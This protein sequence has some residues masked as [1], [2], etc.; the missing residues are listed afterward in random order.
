[1]EISLDAEKTYSERLMDF[2]IG[3]DYERI[4]PATVEAAKLHMLDAIGVA[5]VSSRSD[6]AETVT[7]TANRLGGHADCSVFGREER[8][9]A[10]SAAFV[11]ASMVHTPDYD[12]THGGSVIH[13]SSVVVPVAVAIAEERGIPGK[14]FL[15]AL[16]AGYEI[17]LRIGLCA[18]GKFHRNGFHPT[19]ACG[20][21]GSTAVAARLG[22]LKKEAAV[23][24]IGIAGSFGS[25]LLE[26]L[27]DGSSAKRIHP[28]WAS[29]GG[30][31]A[32]LLAGNGLTGPR[33]VFEGPNGF[34]RSHLW[35]AEYGFESQIGTLGNRWETEQISYK[36]YPCCHFLMAF[37]DCAR[38]IRERYALNPLDIESV[39]CV[40][41]PEQAELVCEPVEGRKR[42]R[43]PYDA[44]FSLPYAAALGI[45][46]G[47]CVLADFT[48]EAI[49]DEAVLRLAGKV[50]YT[51]SETT[52]YPHV[53][54]G[55]LKV[56][57]RNGTVLEHRENTQRGGPDNPVGPED[58]VRK[59]ENNARIVFSEG[60]IA[61]IRDEV[62][63]LEKCRD[64]RMFTKV[65]RGDA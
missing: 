50:G 8:Y 1:M 63:A 30:I 59:F 44:K 27:S 11:N 7:A 22:G 15:I 13:P 39:E 3:L 2:A 42:P 20:V 40:I 54:P 9:P 45:L 18:P 33:T 38:G 60:R 49:R 61:A 46:R 65:L 34:F 6:T 64:M 16:V 25:G 47:D 23:H 51:L 57:M 17:L 26:F 37:I 43:T 52:G 36:L 29:Y 53:F 48:E 4:P 32:S 62:L 14:E 55:W 41:A 56:R 24:A 58:I 35:G 10:S 5:L 28:G 21:F 19:G 12:D 31:F